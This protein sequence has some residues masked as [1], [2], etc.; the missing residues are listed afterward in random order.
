MADDRRSFSAA[1]VDIML[2]REVKK[3]LAQVPSQVIDLDESTRY[4]RFFILNLKVLVDDASPIALEWRMVRADLFPSF[5]FEFV[6]VLLLCRC[7]SRPYPPKVLYFRN[8]VP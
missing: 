8:P 6:R 7:D 4:R 3:L 1:S 2:L 5:D